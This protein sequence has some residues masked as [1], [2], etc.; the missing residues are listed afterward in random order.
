MKRNV[1]TFTFGDTERRGKKN[2]VL[3]RSIVSVLIHLDGRRRSTKTLAVNDF[4]AEILQQ[5]SRNLALK[6]TAWSAAKLFG[7][8]HIPRRDNN[9][10]YEYDMLHMKMELRV[11]ILQ[12]VSHKKKLQTIGLCHNQAEKEFDSN[13][14]FSITILNFLFQL[15]DTP[16][17]IYTSPSLHILSK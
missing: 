17:L 2:N 8:N 3:F 9:L 4:T 16:L 7:L 13:L 5:K 15:I 12:H 10:F 6:Q 11:F 1:E 14:S